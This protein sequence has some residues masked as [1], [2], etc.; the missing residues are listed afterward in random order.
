MLALTHNDNFFLP[1]PQQKDGAAKKAI[2]WMPG[3]KKPAAFARKIAKAV[4][5][6]FVME[7]ADA[8]SYDFS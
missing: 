4:V 6:G 1:A 8:D 3:M 2:K 7:P 5:G